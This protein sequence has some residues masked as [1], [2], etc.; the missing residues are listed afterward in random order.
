MEILIIVAAEEVHYSFLP[1]FVYV[2]N[3]PSSILLKSFL[4]F[5]KK[6][7]SHDKATLKVSQQNLAFSIQTNVYN[8]IKKKI[9]KASLGNANKI[10]FEVSYSALT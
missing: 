5:S 6:Q 2:W 8:R 1:P 4:N 10:R 7:I 3:S 9:L